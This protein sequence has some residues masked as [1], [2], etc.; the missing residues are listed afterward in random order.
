MDRLLVFELFLPPGKHVPSRH[1][2]P[3]QEEL[4]TILSGTMRFWLGWRIVLAKPGD[5]VTV[6]RGVAHWFGNAGPS[7]S[8]ARVEVRPAL[9]TQQLFETAAKV[10]FGEH[11]SILEQVRQLPNVARML[12]KFRREVA[13]PDLPEWIVHPVLTAVARLGGR[14]DKSITERANDARDLNPDPFRGDVSRLQR[15]RSARW[16]QP[17]PPRCELR[18]PRSR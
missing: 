1:T 5:T 7:E 6:P 8:R 14:R 15:P 12:L 3:L 17:L 18:A 2:H 16:W 10:E 13:V 4:F 9:Q 11:P